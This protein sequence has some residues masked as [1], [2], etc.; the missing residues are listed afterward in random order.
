MN[1]PHET[2]VRFRF[3][4]D[5]DDATAELTCRRGPLFNE[6]SFRDHT[7]NQ[8]LRNA[9]RI[10][11]LSSMVSMSAC[12]LLNSGGGPDAPPAASP[13]EKG[14]P[15]NV[16]GMGRIDWGL[17]AEVTREIRNGLIASALTG[18]LSV[19]I[20]KDFVDAC[21]GIAEMLGIDK[22]SLVTESKEQ[23]AQAEH[24]CK[25]A[26]A[27]V[28]DLRTKAGGTV[29][30]EIS[31]LECS[32]KMGAA[33][34]CLAACGASSESKCEGDVRGKCGGQCD[35]RCD[36]PANSQCNGQCAGSCSGSC[37]SQFE[38][39]CGGVC[40][41]KCNGTKK[42]GECRGTCIGKCDKDAKGTCAG[43]C[44]GACDSTCAVEAFGQCDGTCTG[45][46]SGELNEAVCGGNLIIP[47]NEGSC[48]MACDALLMNEFHCE[49]PSVKL[50]VKNPANGEAAKTLQEIAAKFGPDLAIAKYQALD[51]DRVGRAAA[52]ATAAVAAMN[53]A[54]TGSAIKPSK[55]AESCVKDATAVVTP[56]DAALPTISL[57]GG[58][59]IDATIKE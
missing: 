38:G 6:R 8:S 20:E 21:T 53:T 15:K 34:E 36:Y 25:L 11:L 27:A 2:L 14:C 39:T 44:S 23:G 59:I 46:C 32:T 40:S 7:M 42:N 13:T 37:E 48:E 1:F 51:Y 49:R 41:G 26:S 47:V 5:R 4:L 56:I 33:D 50:T 12:A 22:K 19:A 58:A 45:A 28:S 35:G 55:I 52:H 31:S 16:E 57:S 18:P 17:D 54:L 30:V 24:V 43:T 3:Y 29:S 10:A 9:S